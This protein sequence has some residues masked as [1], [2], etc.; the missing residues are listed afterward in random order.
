MKTKL[1]VR[2]TESAIMIALATV[3]SIATF[4]KL[5][6]GGSVTIVS[7]LPIAIIAYRHGTKWGL[8]TGFTYGLV[9]MMLGL[10]NF[11][12]VTGWKSVIAVGLLDYILAFVVIGLA[13]IFKNKIKGKGFG[14][15]SGVALICVLR[16]AMHVVSGITVWKEVS[17]PLEDAF[18]Y[19]LLYNASYMLPESLLTIIGAYFVAEVFTLQQEQIKRIPLATN[20]GVKIYTALPISI[21]VTISAVLLLSLANTKESVFDISQIPQATIYQWMPLMVVMACGIIGSI[22]IPRFLKAKEE[23]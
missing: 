13:G 18:N 11:S 5:P 4:I 8:L 7:M 17:I 21:A 2:V 1:S 20:V 3:L 9:Q 16:Y 15:A 19:S 12:Y 23:A 6:Y 22:L 10:E 14:F